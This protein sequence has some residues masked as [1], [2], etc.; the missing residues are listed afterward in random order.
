[1]RDPLFAPAPAVLARMSTRFGKEVYVL[2]VID[3]GGDAVADTSVCVGI[4]G[5][6]FWV[7]AAESVEH[8]RV[9]G[10]ETEDPVN[11]ILGK[12]TQTVCCFGINGED[13]YSQT[14]CCSQGRGGRWGW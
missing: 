2:F 1:M 13:R 4:L 5:F 11:L 12:A 3:P 14:G 9:E 8:T 7:I 10:I 6:V